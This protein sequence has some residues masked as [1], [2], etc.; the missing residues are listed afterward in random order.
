MLRLSWYSIV[1]NMYGHFILRKGK[2]IFVLTHLEKKMPCTLVIEE[3][4]RQD[5]PTEF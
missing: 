2:G 1:L 5:K 4:G 3:Q